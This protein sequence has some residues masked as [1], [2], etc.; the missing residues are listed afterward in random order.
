VLFDR[1]W[2]RALT[3]AS[4]ARLLFTHDSAYQDVAFSAAL[5]ADLGVLVF[6]QSYPEDYPGLYLEHGHHDDLVSVEHEL[7]GFDHAAVSA[8]L[9]SRWSFPQ[10]LIDAVASH[11]R[12]SKGQDLLPQAVYAASLLAEVLWEP[13]RPHMAALQKTLERDFQL[14]ID[15][16]IS[17]ALDCKN[18]FTECAE[19]FRV[20]VTA[21]DVDA[22]ALRREAHRQFQLA[23]IDVSLELD[24]L[25]AIVEDRG[26]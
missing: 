8:R 24:T 22:D 10:D 2:R 6:A 7:Y 23:A 17:L 3:M 25:E 15:G 18:A 5:F 20:N 4:A 14:D 11:Q 21:G 12:E 1:Y 9:L 13:H 16:L 19:L 26:D